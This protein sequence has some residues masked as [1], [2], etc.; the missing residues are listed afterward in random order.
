MAD[1]NSHAKSKELPD[2]RELEILWHLHKNPKM[3]NL[4]IANQMRITENQVRYDRTN[5][6][7]KGWILEIPRVNLSK[8]GFPQRY[9][10]DVWVDQRQ[11][12]GNAGG[13]P[14]D[15]KKVGTQR[16][17]ALYIVQ[18]LAHRKPFDSTILIEDILILLGGPADLTTIVRA[19]N[20][21][22][23]LDFVTEGLR[24]CGGISQTAT[25][26]EQRSYLTGTL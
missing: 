19:V 22:A 23:M 7:D 5:M 21:D 12:K 11:L 20:N 6:K 24:M 1:G 10:V 13:M 18:D 8:L 26:L 17:L 9:R 16:E 14:G 3:S 4:E 25:C 15:S 2:D